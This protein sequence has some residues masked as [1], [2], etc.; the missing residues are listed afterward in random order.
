MPRRV[1]VQ[2]MAGCRGRVTAAEL[3]RVAR[4]VLAAEDVASAVEVEIVLADES[5][6]R[7]LNRLYRGKDESTDVLSFAT[8]EESEAFVGSPDEAPSLGEVIVCL[9]VAE[10]Q[11][12]RAEREVAGEVAHLEV[13]GLLHLLGYDHEEADDSAKM[14]AREDDLLTGMGYAGQYAHGE[15]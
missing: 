13:H 5:T 10:A 6:V 15:H 1:P 4:T 2:V 14:Q 9:P 7:D 11:A 12:S 8:R 3:R